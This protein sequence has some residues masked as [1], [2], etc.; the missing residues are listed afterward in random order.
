[1]QV[2]QAAQFFGMWRV[3]D[4]EPHELSLVPIPADA[5]AQIRSEGGKPEDKA[6]LYRCE[7]IGGSADQFGA[8]MA[9][10]RMRAASITRRIGR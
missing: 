7:V 8:A 10:M 2:V 9:R 1:L 3:V 6:P 5:G 4:W